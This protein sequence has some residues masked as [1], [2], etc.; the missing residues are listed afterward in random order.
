ML[1]KE[2]A[3]LPSEGVACVDNNELTLLCADAAVAEE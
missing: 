2:S 1:S 3:V